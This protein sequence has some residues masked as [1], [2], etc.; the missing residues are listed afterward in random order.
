MVNKRR[1]VE[2]GILIVTVVYY[3]TSS[4]SSHLWILDWGGG[5]GGGARPPKAPLNLYFGGE[6]APVLVV[7]GTPSALVGV[8][9]CSILNEIGTVTRIIRVVIVATDRPGFNGRLLADRTK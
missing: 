3:Y 7:S 4:S 5:G 6:F 9:L 8:Y 1:I 2:T